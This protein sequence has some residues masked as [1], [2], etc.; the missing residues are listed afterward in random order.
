[1]TNIEKIIN[2]LKIYANP[3][4]WKQIEIEGNIYS[5]FDDE[6]SF[7]IAK[8]ALDIK[9][10]SSIVSIKKDS[11]KISKIEISKNEYFEQDI[12]NELNRIYDKYNIFKK[13]NT[14]VKYVFDSQYT[15]MLGKFLDPFRPNGTLFDYNIEVKSELVF[16]PVISKEVIEAEIKI[17]IFEDK[18]TF[19]NL[20]F[21]LNEN[22]N[23]SGWICN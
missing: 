16:E 11:E 17:K 6:Q 1:M 10:N 3:S 15:A 5:I 2:A 4:K 14:L 12:L 21:K 13:S 7:G 20:N 19:Y 23:E 22:N 9:N 18:N 8:E